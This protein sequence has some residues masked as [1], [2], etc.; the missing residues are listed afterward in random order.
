M[1]IIITNLKRKR[2]RGVSMIEK[3]EWRKRVGRVGVCL[4]LQRGQVRKMKKRTKNKRRYE[5]KKSY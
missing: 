5:E 3:I 1:I 2:L 4:E